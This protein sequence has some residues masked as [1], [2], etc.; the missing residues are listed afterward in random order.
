MI[1]QEFR[2][3]IK[4]LKNSKEERR[5]WVGW[6]V[7]FQCRRMTLSWLFFYFFKITWDHILFKY[8]KW[9]SKLSILNE[10]AFG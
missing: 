3:E 9:D 6:L 5:K 8:K 10:V 1:V 2:I 4:V 7:F